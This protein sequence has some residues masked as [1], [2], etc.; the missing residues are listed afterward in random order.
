MARR[1][2]VRIATAARKHAKDSVERMERHLARGNLAGAQ[3]EARFL[4]AL[5]RQARIEASRVTGNRVRIPR[6]STGTRALAAVRAGDRMA[7]SIVLADMS[8]DIMEPARVGIG[9]TWVWTAN[10]NACSACL[11]EHGRTFPPEA[12]FTPMHRSCHCLPDTP[13][14]ARQLTN[15][16]I[17]NLLV[18]RGGRDAKLGN[19]LLNG[20]LDPGDMRIRVPGGYAQRHKDLPKTN[21]D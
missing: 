4:N 19:L 14:L 10:H 15:S 18:G 11:L 21:S 12:I 7:K 5:D 20:D 2:A 17:G 9:G 13:G 3:R 8:F 6:S 1:D 16:E